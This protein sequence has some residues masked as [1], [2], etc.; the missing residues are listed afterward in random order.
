MCGLLV[1]ALTTAVEIGFP[2]RTQKNTEEVFLG[3]AA[4]TAMALRGLEGRTS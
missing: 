4:E 1:I 3:F 2:A